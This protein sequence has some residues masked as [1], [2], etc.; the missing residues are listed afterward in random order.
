M[1]DSSLPKDLCVK[2]KDARRDSS[3]KLSEFT[4]R[5]VEHPVDIL[6]KIEKEFQEGEK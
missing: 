6:K 5:F 2:G 4:R 1:K 3:E